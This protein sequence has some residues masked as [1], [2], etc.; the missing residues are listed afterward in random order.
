MCN[1]LAGVDKLIA[2]NF[3]LAESKN[4]AR[5]KYNKPVLKPITNPQA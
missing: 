5:L 1:Q 2:T 4:S 3:H